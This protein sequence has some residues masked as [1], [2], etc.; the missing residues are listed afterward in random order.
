M[1]P[2]RLSACI[3]PFFWFI[4]PNLPLLACSV[5]C[6]RSAYLRLSSGTQ[7]WAVW[8]GLARPGWVHRVPLGTGPAVGPGFTGI[9]LGVGELGGQVEEWRVEAPKLDGVAK[10]RS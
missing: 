6:P 4:C 2:K 9:G 3:C 10:S 8:R 5:P 7:I 1:R